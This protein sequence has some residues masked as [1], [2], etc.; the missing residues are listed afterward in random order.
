MPKA[1]SSQQAI[2]DLET[3]LAFLEPYQAT[4]RHYLGQ[5]IGRFIGTFR[6][7][8][9]GWHGD[10]A[11]TV[12]DLG[13]H[14][15]HQSILYAQAGFRVIAADFPAT[16]EI[17]GVRQLADDAGIR[18]LVYQELHSGKA[19]DPLEDDSVDIVLFSEILEHITFNPVALWSAI[20]RI[21]KPGGKI[22]VTTPNYY[23][24]AATWSSLRR[25]FAGF[26][27]GITVDE[28]LQTPTYGH[29]WKEF[30][31]KEVQ[32]YF[33]ALSEDFHIER[34]LH[35]GRDMQIETGWRGKLAPQ[36]YVEAALPRKEKG[37]R[38]EPAW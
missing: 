38:I 3:M 11:A 32:H 1:P 2:H 24:R 20:Y 31:L 8:S 27:G 13:A 12:L 23:A 21:L 5:H 28:I 9:E 37:I 33:C 29:H 22:V 19:L 25:F 14:W 18:L 16:L 15:L 30:T 36:L 4:D 26:G 35:V 10:P 7:V 6:L 34:S 17:Q